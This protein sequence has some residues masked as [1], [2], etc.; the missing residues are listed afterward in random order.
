MIWIIGIQ[1]LVAL[2]CE[3]VQ[4]GTWRDDFEDKA[5]NEWTIYNLDRRVKSGGLTTEKQWARFSTG[6]T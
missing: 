1:L 6:D 2:P 5:T 4:S 3:I